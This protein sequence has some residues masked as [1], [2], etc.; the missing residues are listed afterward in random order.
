MQKM[1]D[2]ETNMMEKKSAELRDSD[3]ISISGGTRITLDEQDWTAEEE[4]IVRRKF[5]WSITPT[6]TLL[7]LCCAIDRYVVA[8]SWPC[9]Q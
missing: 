7:Y 1:H 9:I 5:D 2:V 6:A 4:T 8:F 3:D